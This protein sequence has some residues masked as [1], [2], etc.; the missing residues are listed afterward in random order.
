MLDDMIGDYDEDTIN[1]LRYQ[2]TTSYIDKDKVLCNE[3]D[4]LAAAFYVVGGQVTL[5]MTTASRSGRGDEPQRGKRRWWRD[6]GP[7]RSWGTSCSATAT[8]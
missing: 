3:G 6:W 5:T 4:D 7:A 2:L 8:R 1:L